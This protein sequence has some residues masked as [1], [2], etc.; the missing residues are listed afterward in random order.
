MRE[1][2]LLLCEILNCNRADLYLNN[3]RL[4][5]PD[6]EKI[7]LLKATIKRRM[8]SEPIQYIL[9]KTEFMGLE[10]RVAPGVFIP[11]PETEILVEKAISISHI[12]YRISPA[13]KI[14]D[15]GTGSGNIAV[16]LAKNIK[17]VNIVAVDISQQAI[18]LAK[19]NAQLHSVKNKIEFIKADLFTICDKRYAICDFDMIISN[20]PYIKTQDIEHLAPEIKYEPRIALDGAEDGLKF[21]RQIIKKAADYL[22]EEGYLLMEMG[23]NQSEAIKDI[24]N[25][26]KQ[27]EIIE[28]VLDYSGIERVIVLKLSNQ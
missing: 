17:N 8:Q 6:P 10:F 12:A 5:Q 15:I 28:T 1:I 25:E 27:F 7:V 22:K 19:E 20:P 24:I 4:S 14:L 16:S 23:F 3:P 11:R 2:E 21:Y 9:G 18:E 13:A 26:T